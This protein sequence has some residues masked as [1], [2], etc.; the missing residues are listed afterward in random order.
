[1]EG[2][3]VHR[4]VCFCLCCEAWLWTKSY[5]DSIIMEMILQ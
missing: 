4:G 3:D 2:G 1:V 5:G